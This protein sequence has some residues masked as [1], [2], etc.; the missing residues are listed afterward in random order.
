MR[1]FFSWTITNWE[2][3]FDYRLVTTGSD[4]ELGI[5]GTAHEPEH[6]TTDTF[7]VESVGNSLKKIVEA[8]GAVTQ[9]KKAVPGIGYVAYCT[10]TEEPVWCHTAR[11]V[12]EIV[13]VNKAMRKKVQ[14][15]SWDTSRITEKLPILRVVNAFPS[16]R[17][18]KARL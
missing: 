17:H 15:L 9:P 2:G 14:L 12:Y 18:D 1:K 8:G 13:A 16:D 5:H 7:G 6:V 4:D 3:P 11:H 10:D